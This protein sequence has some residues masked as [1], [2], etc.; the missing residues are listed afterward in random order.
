MV[1]IKRF[2]LQPI[3]NTIMF[4][5][6]FLGI[7]AILFLG[8]N[9]Q[10]QLNQTRLGRTLGQLQGQGAL[11]E[12]DIANGL[13]EA[14]RVGITNGSNQAS[15]RDGYLGNELIRVAFPPDARRVEERLR[16]I[17]LGAEV[18][19]F[20]VS[21]N[22]A[23]EDAAKASLP[24]FGAAITKMT[25]QDAVGIL[26]G[27]DDAATQY[28]R[29]TSGQELYNTFYPIVDSTLN[30]NQTTR[31]YADLVNTY[32]RIPLVQRVNPNLKQY[33]TE[34]A[35]NG[36]FV[37]IA[38]EERKIRQDPAARVNDILRRVFSQR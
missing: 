19:R 34:Q 25:I 32:N 20:I 35:I 31:I 3:S 36:L 29:R 23:A 16:Q 27:N 26:R 28:L 10:A 14:L 11:S 15:Q 7:T 5:H 4:K 12:A 17:G 21:L 13:R 38:Q 30:L 37:L 24:V 18:D 33:A 9:S 22:R 2:Y 8:C 6:L 1:S